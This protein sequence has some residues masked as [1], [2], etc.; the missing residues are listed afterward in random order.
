MT[1]EQV[2]PPW[3]DP[4]LPVADRVEALLA[5]MTLE[6]KVAQLG[7][8]WVGNDMGDTGED[9]GYDPEEQHNVAPMQDVFAAGG[10]IA[11]ADA[12][13]HGLGHL[14]RVYG[15]VPRTPAEGAAELVEQQRV[16]MA[17][18]LGIP[19][20]VH[21]ECLTGFT[22]FGATVYPAA[23]AW[24]ATFDPELI[25][26]MAAAIGRDMAALGV[27]QGLSPVLDVIR[28][29]RWGRVEETIGED[30][31]LVSL[32]GAAY[33]RGLQSGGVIATLKH[34]AG[35]SASRGAR[36][37][38]P[39]PMGRRELTDVVL[40][41]FETA[42]RAGGA[43][44]VMNSYSDVDGVPAG[45]DPWLLTELLRDE[46]GFTGTV[47]SDYW[48]VPFLATMHGVAEDDVDAGAQALIAGIDVELPDTIGFG[49]GLI[50]RVRR[51]E[52]S[53]RYV[54]RAARR[55]LTQKAE[56]GL[57]DPDWSPEKSVAAAPLTDLNA[58]GNQAL[59][60]ELAERSI[61]LLEPGTALPV[62]AAGRIAVLG[63]CAD[64]ARTF[65]G[66]YAFP[67]HVLPRYPQ[68]G[69]GLEIPT[70]LDGLRAEFPAGEITYA[71][72][73]E[74]TGDDRGGFAAA[75]ETARD[76]D[77]AVAFVGDLAGLFGKGTSGEG[78]DAADLRL[79]GVQ[80]ELLEELL[81]TGTPLV[82]VV[83]SG[84]PY[85]LG[86]L[87]GRVAG[88]VQAFM[89]GQAGG[90]AIAG[91]L[92]GRV[93]PAGR[94][95]VQIPRHPGGQ[96]GTYL[97]PI[98]GATHAEVSNLDPRPLYDFGYGRSYTAFAV[99]D[100]RVSA[101]TV[102]TDGEF[103]V[104]V[105]VRNTGERDGAEVVQLYLA[106]PVAQVTR[107]VRQLSGFR[108]VELAAGAAADVTFTVHTDRTAFTG[109]DLR[110]I[111]EPG[112]LRI[113]VGTSAGDLPCSAT[114]RLTGP[115]R[116]AGADRRLTTGVQVRPIAS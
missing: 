55:L 49:A 19:A 21:E 43:R 107:P 6:E 65:L 42:I 97:Q 34:F 111:V 109:R 84:R 40:P 54:D 1:T 78:C 48:A 110:R 85:A 71:R 115:T 100:L 12:A 53:E 62:T 5:A 99:G 46:W 11:L 56:L 7:S 86:D 70:A 27:H 113:L 41:P 3:R 73:C 16:V 45:A 66:C 98:L 17:S 63:P 81:A 23:I 30:P 112:E 31:Y 93:Q 36:N 25:E 91:V 9:Q 2:T 20:I 29:Y 39:V 89:P 13:R 37:H 4:S 8:R 96:P 72:G 52:L 104:T 26:R 92:S 33:V 67:N 88:L 14:T 57:L 105:R 101:D 60:A 103:T 35:Y 90:A 74:V 75:V 38:G 50:E 18:R 83:V 44:S 79:P 10:S 61:V 15:S 82:V 51:G 77:L 28:D 76:A 95:P 22:A 108:R 94:L 59:A 69:L 64:D 116:A 32:I 47:V 114:V 58:A 24:G 102:P 68:L 106:D 80:P 87:D